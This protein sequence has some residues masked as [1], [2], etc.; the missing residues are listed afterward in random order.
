ME[1]GAVFIDLGR[2]T[3]I[4]PYEEQIPGERFRPGERIQAYL[5]SV[6]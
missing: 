4:I 1:R 5:Y 3:G 2:A 6:V